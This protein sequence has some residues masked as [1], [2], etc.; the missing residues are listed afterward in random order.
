MLH[1]GFGRMQVDR[2]SRILCAAL[3]DFLHNKFSTNRDNAKI[4][5]YI[6]LADNAITYAV[7]L[8][9]LHNKLA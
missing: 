4:R 9:P 6:V 3:A 7:L 1:A 5:H 2:K 8:Y